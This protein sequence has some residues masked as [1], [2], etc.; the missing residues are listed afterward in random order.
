MLV[1][2]SIVCFSVKPPRSHHKNVTVATVIMLDAFL[3]LW[4]VV[5][6]NLRELS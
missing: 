5:F 2:L 1:S 6:L 3:K 4:H